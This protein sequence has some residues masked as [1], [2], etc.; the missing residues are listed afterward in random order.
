MCMYVYILYIPVENIAVTP[1]L[2]SSYVN[3]KFPVR[4]L[5]P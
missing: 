4:H 5:L 3:E 1:V 2:D